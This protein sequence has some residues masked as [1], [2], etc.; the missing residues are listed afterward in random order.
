[1]DK[2]A[3][4]FNIGPHHQLLVM[5]TMNEEDDTPEITYIT[6]VSGV[7]LER[8]T[9]FELDEVIETLDDLWETAKTSFDRVSKTRAE[10]IFYQ[11][12]KEVGFFDDETSNAK[13]AEFNGD[14]F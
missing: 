8:T 2:F 5:M 10:K 12:L 9:A 1:M 3:K 4:L 11:M 6:Q 14:I 7:M 13:E